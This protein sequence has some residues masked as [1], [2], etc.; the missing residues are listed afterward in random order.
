MAKDSERSELSRITFVFET[1]CTADCKFY[2]LAVSENNRF[3]HMY[4]SGDDKDKKFVWM[5]MNIHDVNVPLR[6]VIMSGIMMWWSSGKAAPRNS[7]TPTWSRAT[8]PS[9]SHGHLN[10]QT[11]L[12]WWDTTAHPRYQCWCLIFQQFHSLSLFFKINL[13][14]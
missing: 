2:F 9:P 6:R 13:I 3:C 8:V 4:G 12:T 5:S 7:P 11:N 14:N 1:T 10:E